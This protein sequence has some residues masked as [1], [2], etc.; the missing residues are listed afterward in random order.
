MKVAYITAGAAGMY[1]GSCMR[2]NLLVGALRARGVDALLIPTY[3][4]IRTDVEDVSEGRVFYGGIGVYLAQRF[5]LWRKV[6]RF[7]P[8]LLASPSLLRLLSRLALKNRPDE[9]GELTLSI[10]RGEQG[11]QAEELEE[12]YRWL[13][14]EVRP[15]VIHLT[16]ALFV[17]L[18]PL[19][20]ER[21]KVP[22]LCSLQGEDLFLDGLSESYRKQAL[23]LIRD[24]GAHVDCFISVSE[25]Y[26]GWMQEYAG[27]HPDRI[28]VVY[29]GVPVTRFQALSG[30]NTDVPGTPEPV[31]I[32][33]LARICQEKGV[34]L[35][36][37]AFARLKQMPRTEGVRLR[38]AGYLGPADR[39]FLDR[40]VR[41]LADAGLGQ[42]VDVMGTVDWQGKCDLLGSVDIFS[43][44]AVYREPLGLYVLEALASG[45]PVVLPHHGAFP[46][47][48]QATDGGLLVEP[49]S[50][51]A[52]AVGLYQLVVDRARRQQLGKNGQSAVAAKFTDTVMATKTLEVYESLLK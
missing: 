7:L 25:Y 9:L 44:P 52:L 29:P 46:E 48:I 21:M 42:E 24:R 40:S 41:Q 5:P 33:Y 47:I 32:G 18:A 38:I 4:P 1:C 10:L 13:A 19:L 2:D 16:N 27:L 17:G 28:R 26:R 35:L 8:R 11:N 51:E 36:A 30:S 12:L 14:N 49:A 43:V 20:R 15:D 37:E 45:I 50:P 31:V 22:I 3:T 6:P 34:G 23:E 39:H